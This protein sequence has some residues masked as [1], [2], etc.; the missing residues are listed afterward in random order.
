MLYFIRFIMFCADA[1]SDFLGKNCQYI[2]GAIAFYT[3][4]SLFP[5]SLAVIS[6]AGFVLGSRAEETQLAHDIA[7]IVPISTDFIGDTM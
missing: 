4:F 1:V 5:L 7:A 2:A 3:L 6:V